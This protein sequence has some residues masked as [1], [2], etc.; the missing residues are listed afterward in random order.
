MILKDQKTN[1]TI[2]YDELKAK[3]DKICR[4]LGFWR[5]NPDKRGK[6]VVLSADLISA[7][8]PSWYVNNTQYGMPSMSPAGIDSYTIRIVDL[9]KN[10]WF[11]LGP[12]DKP[13]DSTP[14]G[15]ILKVEDKIFKTLENNT[16]NYC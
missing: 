16:H 14:D 10:L 2:I 1:K 12:P 3:V 13:L 5:F 4:E 9:G 11:G 8:H 15:W 6:D 7:N